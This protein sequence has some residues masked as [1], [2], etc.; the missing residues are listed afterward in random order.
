MFNVFCA[1]Q[2]PHRFATLIKHLDGWT[3]G[4]LVISQ[5]EMEECATIDTTLFE[6]CKNYPIQH[7]YCSIETALQLTTEIPEEIELKP[8]KP[9]HYQEVLQTFPENIKVQQFNKHLFDFMPTLGAFKKDTGGLM[10]WVLQHNSEA[11][12]GLWIQPEYRRQGLAKLLVRG[13]SKERALQG[14]PTQ[15]VVLIGNTPSE[16][17]FLGTGF[18]MDYK[19]AYL[20]KK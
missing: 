4:P 12:A 3:T 7:Y 19:M 9:D 18:K 14:K 17:T 8:L 13:I 1:K 11:L 6:D 10:G 16:R 15:C 2:V 20:L 5:R